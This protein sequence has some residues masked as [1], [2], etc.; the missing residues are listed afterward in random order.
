MGTAAVSCA[1]DVL[2][3]EDALRLA[4]ERNGTIRSAHLRVLSAQS[5][6]RR[7]FG[8]F[9]PTLTPSFG[10]DTST[11]QRFTGVPRGN[12]GNVLNSLEIRAGWQILDNGGRLFSY[13]ASKK[14]AQAESFSGT[15]TLRNVLFVV[16]QQYLDAL[17]A[18]ELLNVQKSQ[19]QRAETILE[20]TRTRVEVGDAAKKDILQASADALNA[21][22]SL[23]QTENS[24]ATSEASLKATIGWPQT[25]SLPP[26]APVQVA[27]LN[28]IPYTLDE[29]IAAG[30]KNRADLQASRLDI[31]AQ[32]FNV[33]I[34][35]ANAGINYS[36]DASVRQAFAQDVL[37][38]SG[39]TLS[40]T[41]PLYD[42]ARSKETIRIQELSL[43]SLQEALVQSERDARAEIEAAYKNYEQNKLRV[44]ATKAA[45]EASKV[46]YEAAVDSQ[47]SGAGNLL[48]VLTAQVSLTTAES[49]DIQASYDLMI[50]HV[51]LLLV[52]GQPVLGEEP[53]VNLNSKE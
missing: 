52:M 3:L 27:S 15:Q 50:S 13:E 12:S 21:R 17:R 49:N 42:G 9:L 10:Y 6:A 26:L 19:L 28:P 48:E 1:Q 20:Q 25:D 46:N 32:R 23:L 4:R 24:V 7:T 43:R 5:A 29:A 44:L 14:S 38:N 53:L 37:R 11:T 39:L 31:E 22:A 34:A 8:A 40:A 36:L 18:Q 35:R 47:K 16:H 51:Q 2:R 33:R 30:I 45:L 41:V